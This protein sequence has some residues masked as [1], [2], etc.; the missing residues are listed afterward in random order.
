MIARAVDALLVS[1]GCV[2]SLSQVT[3]Y[4]EIAS[5]V[6]TGQE[7]IVIAPNGLSEVGRYPGI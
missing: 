3:S 1:S 2:S 7:R 5:K 6:M 4:L